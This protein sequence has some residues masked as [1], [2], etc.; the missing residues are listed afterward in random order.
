MTPSSL[1]PRE[2]GAYAEVTLPL[3]TG[4]LIGG[5][6]L[7]ALALTVAV[8]SAFLAAEPAAVLT[9]VRGE[10]LLQELRRAAQL[11]LASLVLTSVASGIVALLLL[12]VPAKAWLAL[13][14]GLAAGF[15]PIVALGKQK[16][17]PSELLMAAVLSSLVM[18]LAIGGGGD[19]TRAVW[20][21]STWFAVFALATVAVH[22]LKAVHKR[23]RTAR[24]LQWAT[25]VG[26]VAVAVAVLLVWR[27]T[28]LSLPAVA[29]PLLPASMA[30]G[31]VVRPVHPR[32]LRRVGWTIVG[33]NVVV[34]LLLLL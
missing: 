22:T 29:A 20:A 9:G 5:W 8:V 10:R 24:G 1:M 27:L 19:W 18:P 2:H 17:L 26:S 28:P 16:A 3:L 15:V 21:A 32:H 33:V 30:V 23:T 25:A 13:P 34:L 11:R 4:W 7:G 12:P 6:S 31:F 14:T